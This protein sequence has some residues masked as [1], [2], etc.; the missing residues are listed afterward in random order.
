MWTAFAR[1]HYERLNYH[2]A[3]HVTDNEYWLIEPLLPPAKRCGGGERQI[4]AR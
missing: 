3:S 1:T 4:C 2:Y